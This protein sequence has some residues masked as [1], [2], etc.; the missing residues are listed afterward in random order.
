MLQ[1]FY[2]ALHSWIKSTYLKLKGNKIGLWRGSD[3]N[4]GFEQVHDLQPEWIDSTIIHQD[5]SMS[6]GVTKD[7]LMNLSLQNFLDET[8]FSIETNTQENWR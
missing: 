7:E 4:I 3:T 6:S 8:N 5:S 1:K 2:T